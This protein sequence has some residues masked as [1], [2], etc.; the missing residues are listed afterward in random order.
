MSCRV[1]PVIHADILMAY[2]SN[3]PARSLTRSGLDWVNN[4]LRR[5]LSV[6]PRAS[7]GKLL[8]WNIHILVNFSNH[9]HS[10]SF[11]ECQHLRN[12]ESRRQLVANGGFSRERVKILRKRS[13]VASHLPC[14]LGAD[15]KLNYT[16]N[17]TSIKSEWTK[18][19]TTGHHGMSIDHTSWFVYNNLYDIVSGCLQH[20]LSYLGRP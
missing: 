9:F 20:K 14:S 10:N 7:R 19:T 8:T 15:N 12:I 1:Q 2:L 5:A 13:I 3:R 17:S 6:T 16:F 11:H 4:F 18:M